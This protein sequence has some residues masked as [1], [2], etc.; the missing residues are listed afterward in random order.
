MTDVAGMAAAGRLIKT[1]P[2]ADP[3]LQA[4]P[5]QFYNV[6]NQKSRPTT[7]SRSHRLSEAGA[8]VGHTIR[9]AV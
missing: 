5:S 6:S 1:R 8:P 4:S 3:A 2:W 9:K 7:G